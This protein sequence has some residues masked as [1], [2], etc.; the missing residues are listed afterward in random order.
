DG[1]YQ[2]LEGKVGSRRH[3]ANIRQRVD[4]LAVVVGRAI[5]GLHEP[6]GSRNAEDIQI[7]LNTATDEPAV[8]IERVGVE[9]D[10]GARK[11]VQ[12]DGARPVRTAVTTVDVRKNVR[13]NQIAH[14]YACGPRV[15]HLDSAGDTVERI[16][17]VALQAAK[18]AVSE[19]TGNPAATELPIVAD[20][21]GAEP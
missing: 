8:T 11:A 7:V 2:G 1:L 6:A 12:K 4:V 5:L 18:L 9:T 14:A 19:D 16:L 3:I 10:G 17:E 21:D 13:S 20:T 15:L